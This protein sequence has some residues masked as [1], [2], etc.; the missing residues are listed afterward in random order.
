MPTLANG[1]DAKPL[2][3]P[4]DLENLFLHRWMCCCM[5]RT[6][7]TGDFLAEKGLATFSLG[8]MTLSL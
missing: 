7:E 1:L 5:D 6:F 4:A 2:Q 8:L 3:N